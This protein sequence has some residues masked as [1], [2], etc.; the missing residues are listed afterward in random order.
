MSRYGSIPAVILR[1]AGLAC[2]VFSVLFLLAYITSLGRMPFEFGSYIDILISSLVIYVGVIGL[3]G[4]LLFIFGKNVVGLLPYVIGVFFS[5]AFGALSAMVLMTG[6][7]EILLWLPATAAAILP[8]VMLIAAK[9]KKRSFPAIC[10]IGMA[11]HF[12]VFFWLYNAHFGFTFAT[13]FTTY[14]ANFLGILFALFFVALFSGKFYSASY[15][16]E[17]VQK[18]VP[19]PVV[20]T[21]EWKESG[22]LFSNKEY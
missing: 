17:K 6:P 18:N 22:M 1:L 13:F 21:R 5:L 4:F 9:S 14:W 16:R 8:V 7:V 15:G 20:P 19:Q 10:I 3:I 11:I 12:F 2:T